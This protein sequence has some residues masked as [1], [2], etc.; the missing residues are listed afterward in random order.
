VTRHFLHP[1]SLRTR[2]SISLERLRSNCIDGYLLHNPEAQLEWRE[3]APD[4]D[5]FYARIKHAFEFLEECVNKGTIRY[6]GISSNTFHFS[7][8]NPTTINLHRLLK[9]AHTVSSK[10]HFKLIEFPYNLVEN[11]ATQPHHDGV[12]LVELARSNGL[13][14]FANRPLNANTPAGALR[15]AIYPEDMVAPT[16]EKDAQAVIEE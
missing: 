16:N 7:T 1:D 15:L 11:G 4:Q 13:I 8:T 14:T 9:L 3:N 12:S 2:I 6:Y 5:E 10:S